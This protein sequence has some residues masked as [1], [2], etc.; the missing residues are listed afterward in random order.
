MASGGK[1]QDDP[2]ANVI[3]DADFV[4]GARRRE[5]SA[6]ERRGA[7]DRARAE[8][9]R[10]ATIRRNDRRKQRQNRRAIR[11]IGKGRGRSTVTLLVVG[12]VVLAATVWGNRGG[13][14]LVWASGPPITNQVSVTEVRPIPTQAGSTVPLRT[15]AAPVSS[16]GTYGFLALQPGSSVGVTYD[17]C[18]PI[19]VVVN[20]RTAP[21]E[22]ERLVLQ[23]LQEIEAAA[24]FEFRLEGATNEAP[25]LSRPA[26][27]PQRYGDRWAPVLVAWS[28]PAE[29]PRLADQVAGLGGSSSLPVSEK[30]HVYVS[31]EVTLD[32]PQLRE[33]LAGNDGFAQAKAVV[34]HEFGHL[35]GLAHVEDASELMNSRNE[36]RLASFAAGD[37]NGLAALRGAAR[38]QQ[39]L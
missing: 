20:A 4:K 15:P 6:R 17:P 36:G 29:T 31:G 27:Q 39:S 24:G 32:G 28:D 21:P 33:I 37:L 23:A 26:F 38:C 3:L 30:E 14:R 1:D 12:A 5:L 7:A 9:E 13:H 35:L 11:S 2:F 16:G 25:S 34:L 22:G 19:S 18:R 10:L 8:R